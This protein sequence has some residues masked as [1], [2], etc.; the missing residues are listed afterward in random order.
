MIIIELRSRLISLGY[1]VSLHLLGD[2]DRTEKQTSILK[3][4][5]K[6]FTCSVITI[7]PRNM[8]LSLE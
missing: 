1:N 3:I 8:F 4:K 6:V 2:N 5:Y 7:E